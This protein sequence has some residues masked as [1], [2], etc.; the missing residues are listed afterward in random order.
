MLA[1]AEAS[2]SNRSWKDAMAPIVSYT[3]YYESPSARVMM[4]AASIVAYRIVVLAVTSATSRSLLAYFVS[5]S[6]ARCRFL[7]SSNEAGNVN[8]SNSNESM[9][10]DCS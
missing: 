9:M 3:I 10:P 8:C 2:A 6:A 5:S 7:A 4:A 1:R